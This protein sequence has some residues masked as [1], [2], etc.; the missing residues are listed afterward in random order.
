MILINS[1]PKD[2]LKIFQPFLPIFIPVGIGCLLGAC[3]QAGIKTH[4]VD[5][6]VEDNILGC[7][8]KFV[9]D[10]EKPY[11]FGFSVLTAG[12]KS[13]I[14]LSRELK[15]R[16]PDSVILFRGIHPTSAPAQCMSLNHVDPAIS[17]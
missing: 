2:A 15:V 8:D 13:A 1:S 5:E 17:R 16:Y 3:E 12:F 10:M 14:A 6:Q 11:I 4:F 9:G 7:I